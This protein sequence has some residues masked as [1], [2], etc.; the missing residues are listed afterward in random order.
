M[1]NASIHDSA[2]GRSGR[3]LLYTPYR[4]AAR[5]ARHNGIVVDAY[6]IN[7]TLTAS[8]AIRIYRSTTR[9]AYASTAMAIQHDMPIVIMLQAA[10]TP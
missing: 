8:V 5:R 1:G 4:A 9:T 2:E 7:F 3:R 10:Q 6:R